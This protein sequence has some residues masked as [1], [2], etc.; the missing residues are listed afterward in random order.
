MMSWSGQGVGAGA[1]IPCP[2]E[3]LDRA[4]WPMVPWAVGPWDRFQAPHGTRFSIS[5]LH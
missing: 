5:E 2:R 1:T 3:D 4:A